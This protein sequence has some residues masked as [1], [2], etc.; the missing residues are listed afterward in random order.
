MTG[1]NPDT[2]VLARADAAY[3]ADVL[4]LAGRFLD[5]AHL[6][7][8]GSVRSVADLTRAAARLL[9]PGVLPPLRH[10]QESPLT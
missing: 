10:D 3:I 9:P 6:H 1:H 7:D 4:V 5:R 2:V 8:A